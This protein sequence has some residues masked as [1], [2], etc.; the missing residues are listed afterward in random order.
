[1]KKLLSLLLAVALLCALA[2]AALA[3][4]EDAN[5][6]AELLHALG[7][8][9]GTGTKPD[10][11]PNY[12]LDRAPT[13]QEAV[14]MLV[15]LL[16]KEDAARRGNW[17]TPFTDVA[18]WALPYVGYAYSTGLSRG[19][20]AD[21]FGGNSLVSATQYLTFVLRALGY[22]SGTDFRWDAA[23]EFSDAIGLTHGEYPGNG[24]FLRGDVVSISAAALSM[25]QRGGGL[26][27]ERLIAEGVFPRERW[28]ALTAQ[29]QEDP[30]RQ[31]LVYQKLIAMRKEL[32]EGQRWTN[33]N[34]YVLTYH[35][36]VDGRPITYTFA[37]YGCVA[38]AL[39]VSS[40]AFGNL[41]LRTIQR[42]SFRYEDLRVGDMPRIYNNSHT[43]VLLEIHS[44][45][46]VIAEGNY[47]EAIHWG[48]TLTKAEVME[49]D[50][51]WTRYPA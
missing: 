22:A 19:T 33:E 16:G 10:G 37:G 30:Y 23:W 36:T 48:R 20:G 11:T 17:E 1:M 28:N 47:N 2:P 42:G 24:T 12:D 7:L 27:A 15:R 13:R 39:K 46:V 34:Q 31:E 38:F 49:A 40:A 45:H 5:A 18:A 6:A 21:T 44:D 43:V 35:D 8:F 32:P 9:Q 41:P 26:L 25:Q 14:T 50:Y 51:V 3:V 29:T 4:R